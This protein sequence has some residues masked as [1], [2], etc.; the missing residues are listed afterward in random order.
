MGRAF[1][2]AQQEARAGLAPL[3]ERTRRRRTGRWRARA[4]GG[5]GPWSARTGPRRGDDRYRWAGRPHGGPGRARPWRGR[6][7]WPRRGRPLRQQWRNWVDLRGERR[8]RIG[9]GCLGTGGGR[10][11]AAHGDQTGRAETVQ[12]GRGEHERRR[13][14]EPHALPVVEPVVFV[15]E[16]VRERGKPGPPLQARLPHRGIKRQSA[17]ARNRTVSRG[18]VSHARGSTSRLTPAPR[19]A[20]LRATP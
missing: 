10:R 12:R 13:H 15:P 20:I 4:G 17:A 9:W 11:Q 16:S 19:R 14:P 7:R 2:R 1:V 5:R 6:D 18:G 8:W 3:A